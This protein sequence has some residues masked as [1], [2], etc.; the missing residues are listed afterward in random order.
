MK[1]NNLILHSILLSQYYF[2]SGILLI[3]LIAHI[4]FL[5]NE[6][7]IGRI[8]IGEWVQI[9]WVF[10]PLIWTL[11]LLYLLV[12][13]ATKKNTLPVSTPYIITLLISPVTLIIYRIVQWLS[14]KPLML[15]NVISCI[16]ILIQTVLLLCFFAQI[17]TYTTKLIYCN[18]QN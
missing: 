9:W 5:L 3:N 18:I 2:V 11:P 12:I 6:Y 7:K 8:V 15:N 14:G 4:V 10:Y 13:N 1:N 17:I 16:F